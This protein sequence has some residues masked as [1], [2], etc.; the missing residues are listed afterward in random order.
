MKGRIFECREYIGG[1]LTLEEK[2]WK[3]VKKLV[4]PDESDKSILIKLG[5]SWMSFIFQER[6]SGLCVIKKPEIIEL[7]IKTAKLLK[8]IEIP[9]AFLIEVEEY[10]NIENK[11]S[12][13]F[14]EMLN[15]AISWQKDSISSPTKVNY[16]ELYRAQNELV[17][18]AK[19]TGIL[20]E[21][22]N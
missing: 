10:L 16:E 13:D 3:N 22:M 4:I 5:N 17:N 6:D 7:E 20:G 12:K 1:S 9:G 18:L 14:S 19:E 21:L 2:A 11:F 15:V 8:E